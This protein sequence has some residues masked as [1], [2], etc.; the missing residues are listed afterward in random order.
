MNNRHLILVFS[1][2]FI[3]LLGF[4]IFEGDIPTSAFIS[5]AGVETCEGTCTACS[6]FPIQG[7]CAVQEDCSWTT[8]SCTGDPN[9]CSTFLTSIDCENHGCFWNASS[10]KC[11]G[12]P[13][14]CPTYNANESL[15]TS[16][17]CAWNPGA[18]SGTCTDC[19]DYLIQGTCE[20]QSGCSWNLGIVCGDNIK[21]GTEVCDGTDLDSETCI[22]QGFT[23]GTLSC[24]W[25]CSAFDSSGCTVCG[26]NTKETGETCDGTDLD[27]ETCTSQGFD[28]GTLTCQGDCSVFD[29][30][31][32]TSQ[33]TDCGNGIKDSD[34]LC[35]GTDFGGETCISQ[36]YRSGNLFCFYD[37]LRF[38]TSSCSELSEL[39]PEVVDC[40]DNCCGN[41]LCEE[42]KNENFTTC[43]TD[44]PNPA[45]ISFNFYSPE[46]SARFP[47]GE[48]LIVKVEITADSSVLSASD[49]DWVRATGF[50][51][52]ENLYDDG[53]H[54]D[55]AEGDSIYGNSFFIGTGIKAEEHTF[56]VEAKVA[57]TQQGA[58]TKIIVDPVLNLEVLTDKDSYALGETIEI[59]GTVKRSS[60]PTEAPVILSIL[61]ENIELSNLT[62][63][64]NEEGFYILNYQ[65]D[66]S[67]PEGEW[68]LNFETTDEYNNK[69]TA[70]KTINVTAS[71]SQS[72]I[73]GSAISPLNIT[74]TGFEGFALLLILLT[75]IILFSISM[76]LSGVILYFL[77]WKKKGFIPFP[78]VIQ[79][80]KN[81][82]N[83][84]K[85][86]Q[87]SK[88][89][90]K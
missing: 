89:L 43:R 57:V 71:D 81:K 21:E 65:T 45:I 9:S 10:G 4:F 3:L 11:L 20:A 77:R 64:S 1:V 25:D 38:D 33:A 7:T 68:I 5:L 74:D 26:N 6:A 29:T 12:T 42:N 32:C 88:L 46:D 75:T 79:K 63:K 86:F 23:A 61:S 58:N 49:V 36:G 83:S 39:H 76:F 50:F 55:S 34:E 30:S 67:S 28:V 2:L 8:S 35:D 51:G 18:C 16:G 44:C 73:T 24:Q 15:C 87:N 66:N 13:S 37:C 41:S 54:N 47:R 56:T 40:G 19:A 59:S 70:S 80:I 14:P 31:N 62:G 60:T 17:G 85:Y 84:I 90:R 69:G 78:K 48:I 27:E 72:L 52:T 53:L 82:F 22:I